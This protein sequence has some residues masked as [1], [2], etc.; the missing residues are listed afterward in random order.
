MKRIEHLAA[1]S[2][3]ALSCGILTASCLQDP[4]GA[5]EPE[6]APMKSSKVT[7]PA[8]EA[9][10]EARGPLF[11]PGEFIFVIQQEWDGKDK[12]GGWQEALDTPHFAVVIKGNSKEL[13]TWKCPLKIGMPRHTEK[14]GDIPTYR[15]AAL[16]AEIANDVVWPMLEREESWE[17]QGQTF[18]DALRLLMQKLFN[19]RYNLGARVSKP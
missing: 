2:I 3:L 15:A 9:Q 19:E 8:W 7:E 16:S 10:Q 17:G 6:S 12:A 1:A 13:Y 18:C 14:G 4:R 5:P 11:K